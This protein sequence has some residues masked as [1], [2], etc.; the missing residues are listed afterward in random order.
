[1]KTCITEA[2]TKEVV[3]V[4]VELGNAL[5]ATEQIISEIEK[6]DI[7]GKIVL[8]RL[9]GEM[10]S[11]SNSDIKFTQIEET[12]K[13]KG[14]YFML[15]N[16]HELKTKEVELEFEVKN[17][18]NIEEESINL[19][20]EQNPVDFN[21]FI[22]PLMNTLSIDKQEGEKLESFTNRLMEEAKKILNF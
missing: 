11:G 14:A 18:D 7:D 16:T 22:L 10:D 20:S 21:K 3:L 13:R 2:F 8:L 19:Y 15:K 17:I 4:D 6:K 1:L 12:V 5:T 9:R